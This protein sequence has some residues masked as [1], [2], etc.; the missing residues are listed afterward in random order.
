MFTKG[1]LAVGEGV[2]GP[3]LRG[4]VPVLNNQAPSV[5]SSVAPKESVDGL[6][7][8]AGLAC[9]PHLAHDEGSGLGRVGVVL[10][11]HVDPPVANRARVDAAVRP[12]QVP[13]AGQRATQLA[14]AAQHGRQGGGS[15]A[16]V[17][18]A[19][20]DAALWNARP[21]LARLRRR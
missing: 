4:E 12:R 17:A 5:V 16:W 1:D 18:G 19:L 21:S 11:R 15:R 10:R 3:R 20:N 6:G 14:L 9:G 8:G 13:A 2:L 7:R